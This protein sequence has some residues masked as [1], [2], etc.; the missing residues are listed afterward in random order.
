MKNNNSLTKQITGFYSIHIQQL[1][2]WDNTTRTNSAQQNK[3]RRKKKKE[4]KR[5][6]K[7]KKSSE[8]TLQA[9]FKLAKTAKKAM[10]I[11]SRD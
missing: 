7:T 10:L 1:W 2:Y 5:K 8:K 6:K 4:E 9:I 11:R 3:C